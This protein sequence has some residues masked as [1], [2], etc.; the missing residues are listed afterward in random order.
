M[1][2]V[3]GIVCLVG[4]VAI[5]GWTLWTTRAQAQTTAP[6]AVPDWNQVVAQ[7]QKEHENE[8]A[9][10]DSRAP[11]SSASDEQAVAALDAAL[12]EARSR[13]GG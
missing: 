3:I 12:A 10:V 6:T 9:K 4:A 7:A 11:V 1:Y 2:L 5:V 13:R 8:V